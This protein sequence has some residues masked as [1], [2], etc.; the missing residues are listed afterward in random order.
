M[1]LVKE[2]ST[3]DTMELQ[4]Y[5]LILATDLQLSEVYCWYNFFTFNFFDNMENMKD[6]QMQKELP[7]TDQQQVVYVF[8]W[9]FFA[10]LNVQP[11][12][13]TYSVRFLE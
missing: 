1:E 6:L 9:G 11:L 7:L 2:S 12:L 3:L 8:S 4:N 13:I 10:V 5:F